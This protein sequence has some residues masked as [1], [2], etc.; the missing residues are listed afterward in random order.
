[1][2]TDVNHFSDKKTIMEQLISN[3]VQNL[4]PIIETLLNEAM[5]L[6]REMAL[7]AMPY[8]RSADRIGY[9]N[10]YKDKEYASRLGSLKVR[11][12]Q[13]RGISFYPKALEKGE[14]S[15]RAL[16]LAVAEMYVNGVATRKVAEIT[17]ELCGFEISSTQV[18]RCSQLLDEELQKFRERPLR[19][20]Y[21]Y[22]YFDAEYEKVRYDH[23][24]IDMATLI[25]IGVNEEGKREILGVSSKLSEAEIH[26]R[27]FFEE[28]QGRGLS[29]VQLFISDDHKGMKAARKAIFP[30]VK[31]Q[32]C[33]FHMAQNA[34]AYAPKK[35][36]QEE[37]GEALRKIFQSPD[38]ETAQEQKRKCIERYKSSAP[39]FTKWVDSSIE[40]G[41]TCFSYP[42]EHRKRIRTVNGLER[43]NKEIRRRTRVA[44]LFPNV[45]SCERLI[46]AV[47][48][49]IHEDW[50]AGNRYLDMSLLE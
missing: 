7:R 39:E 19:D 31:W 35:S 8:E 48:Q 21:A 37:L 47:L 43:L 23:S 4:A 34:Q 50:S 6:E 18:S 20:K 26:W 29:G 40:E 30:S 15:E 5:L 3:G 38:Y 14:R 46:T 2:T 13:A 41:L 33:Q 22:V 9:A 10:G 17:E 27:A 42:E 24:V 32:R 25:A 49:G 1:M 44:T 16:K 11:I 12:P 28:L 45:K 36:M